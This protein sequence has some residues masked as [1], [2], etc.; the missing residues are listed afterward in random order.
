VPVKDEDFVTRLAREA[1]RR[2]ELDDL[3]SLFADEMRVSNSPMGCPTEIS[4]VLIPVSPK[5]WLDWALE[6]QA[7]K[8]AAGRRSAG[9]K[10][11]FVQPGQLSIW[12]NP[13]EE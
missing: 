1:L 10:S 6:H 4:P 2:A 8:A 11:N 5:T 9:K 3:Q 13:K 12:S 7:A